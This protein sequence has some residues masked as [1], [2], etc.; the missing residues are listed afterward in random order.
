[1]KKIILLAISII[2]QNYIWAQ[3]C[4]EQELVLHKL[5]IQLPDLSK[6]A[7]KQHRL[8]AQ[9]KSVLPKT[10]ESK[11]DRNTLDQLSGATKS[12]YDLTEFLINADRH[13]TSDDGVDYPADQL[14]ELIKKLRY[15]EDVTD[16]K[17]SSL[18]NMITNDL[19]GI[20]PTGIENEISD[21]IMELLPQ[22]KEDLATYAGAMRTFLNNKF[23]LL[24]PASEIKSLYTL[25]NIDEIDKQPDDCIFDTIK[26]INTKLDNLTDRLQKIDESFQYYLPNTANNYLKDL[27]EQKSK[28]TELKQKLSQLSITKQTTIEANL[29]QLANDIQAKKIPHAQFNTHLSFLQQKKEELKELES[30]ITRASVKP[31]FKKKVATTLQILDKQIEHFTKRNQQFS[32]TKKTL[33]AAKSKPNK[34]YQ[35]MPSHPICK[36]PVEPMSAQMLADTQQE[37]HYQR[38]LSEICYLER[39]DGPPVK[40]NALMFITDKTKKITAEQAAKKNAKK[41]LSVCQTLSFLN[42]EDEATVMLDIEGD[43]PTTFI[44]HTPGGEYY[45][46]KPANE[47][48]SYKISKIIGYYYEEGVDSDNEDSEIEFTNESSDEGPDQARDEKPRPLQKK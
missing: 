35:T 36:I 29:A 17:L 10:P 7:E 16:P 25:T 6:Q 30:G 21:N 38:K 1:M 15:K 8:S 45:V 32:K 28:I 37:T 39:K 48:Y 33:G 12:I 5:A 3:E 11:D 14:A 23:S 13:I 40:I 44:S 41:R 4:F 19:L 43:G 18:K 47:G 22:I 26:G 2:F 20:N 42:G 34:D 27:K 46:Y 31:E 9:L 24:F